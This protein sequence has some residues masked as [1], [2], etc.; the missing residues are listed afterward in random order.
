[1]LVGLNLISLAPQRIELP[2]YQN[3]QLQSK[4]LLLPCL[5][6]IYKMGIFSSSKPSSSKSSSS[7]PSVPNKAQRIKA[8]KERTAAVSR[9]QQEALARLPPNSLYIV[10]WIRSDPPVANDFHWGYYFHT[11]SDGGIKYHAR[12]LGSGWIPD[13]G[14][15]KGVFK[16]NFLCVLVQVATVPPARHQAL[17]QIMRARDG[18]LN[19]IPR[20]SCRVWLLDTLGR[21]MQQG[22]VR[23][24]SVDA[25]QQECF[26]IGNHFSSGA[27]GN[28]QPRP[29]V[30]SRV[31]QLLGN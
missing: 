24:P 20:M 2:Q 13:H 21:L 22:I 28:D 9:I 8:A 10:L 27:A 12:N 5:Y 16:S 11:E 31:C 30:Q 6:R 15:T 4:T 23:G 29:V 7:A 25:V 18:Q 19:Q 1:M 17:D 14:K 3:P 26:S